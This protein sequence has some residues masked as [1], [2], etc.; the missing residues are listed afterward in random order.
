MGLSRS[1][2]EQAHFNRM[3]SQYEELLRLNCPAALHKVER[4][5]SEYAEYLNLAPKGLL[6]EIGAGTGWYTRHLAPKIVHHRYLCTDVS[7]KMLE[8]ARNTFPDTVEI[9]IDWRVEDCLH[10]SFEDGSVSVVTGCGILHHL[11]L[12][13]CV[14]EIYRILRV[15]GRI[16]FYEPNLLNPYVFVIKKIPFLRPPLDTPEETALN[17]FS[18]RTLLRD[19]GFENIEITPYQFIVSGLRPSLIPLFDAVN[20]IIGRIPV[21]KYLGGSLK[22]K[23]VKGER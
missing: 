19:Y 18:L 5:S 15:G 23:A 17:P 20:E 13:S 16:A 21:L 7:E 1:E 4:F 6:V 10:S 3:A 8:L 9:D 22:I 2:K 12:E 11:P 14:K